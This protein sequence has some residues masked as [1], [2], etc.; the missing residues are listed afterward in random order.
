[1]KLKGTL[2]DLNENKAALDKIKVNTVDT[3][4]KA[5]AF[6]EVAKNDFSN[7]IFDE[8]EIAEK[9]LNSNLDNVDLFNNFVETAEDCK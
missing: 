9:N 2:V 6:P 1:M 4:K 7:E 3:Y 8:L 5:F